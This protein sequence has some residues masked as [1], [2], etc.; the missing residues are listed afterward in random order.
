M[1]GSEEDRAL[2]TL[3]WFQELFTCEPDAIDKTRLGRMSTICYSQKR[4]YD[5]AKK[6]MRGAKRTIC[7]DCSVHS[8]LGNVHI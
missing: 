2:L 1:L 6:Y 4:Y 3:G 5:G 8:Q 7:R